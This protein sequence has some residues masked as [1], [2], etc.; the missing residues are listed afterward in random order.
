MSWQSK[1]KSV[2][3]FTEHLIR[4][5]LKNYISGDRTQVFDD[6]DTLMNMILVQFHP[7]TASQGVSTISTH[8]FS[9]NNKKTLILDHTYDCC[10]THMCRAEN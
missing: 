8:I 5:C 3:M 6:A 1:M 2:L 10:L 7:H 9:E 4:Q